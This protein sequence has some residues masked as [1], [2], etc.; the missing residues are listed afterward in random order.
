ML[1][2]FLQD[3][4]VYILSEL[5][6]DVQRQLIKFKCNL[7]E[8]RLGTSE[9]FHGSNPQSFMASPR[10]TDKEIPFD[11][12]CQGY[13][14]VSLTMRR[15]CGGGYKSTVSGVWKFD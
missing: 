15:K 14:M 12:R 11:E 8:L 2:T 4:L 13:N 9:V 10:V 3:F 7:R 5:V 6:I 1:C